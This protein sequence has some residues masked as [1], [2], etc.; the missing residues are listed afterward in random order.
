MPAP[1]ASALTYNLYVT[2]VATMTVVNVQTVNGVVVGVDDAFNNLI[3]QMLNYAEL[4]IQRDLDLTQAQVTGI[5]Y[6]LTTGSPMLDIP[7]EDFIVIQ[8]IG[9]DVNGL[10][11]PLMPV[12]REFLQNV[13]PMGS[14]PGAPLY[15][16]ITGGDPATSGNTTR[17]LLFGPPPDMDYP[18]YIGGTRR[19]DTLYEKATPALA[20]TATTFIS[21]Q[22]PDLLLQASMIYISQ[23]QRN[24]GAASNDPQMGP[25][26]EAQYQNLLRMAM[27]EEARKR[28]QAAAWTSQPPAPAASPTRG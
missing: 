27:L 20:A 10:R 26:Y 2:Q 21:S 17:G 12:T 11:M 14:V 28:F 13:Y 5:A 18:V 6:S 15:F 19:M 1:F 25:T 4:R 8:T 16:A 7:L 3:P 22:L 9:V 23:Y 24:F